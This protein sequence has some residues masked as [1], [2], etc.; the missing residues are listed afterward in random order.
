[1]NRLLRTTVG[2]AVTFVFPIIA[3]AQAN[4]PP[5]NVRVTN[6]PLPVTTSGALPVTADTPLPVSL[7]GPLSLA[8][9]TVADVAT[10]QA[11]V[12]VSGR[13]FQNCVTFDRLSVPP[14]VSSF[15]IAD[16]KAFVVTSV[17]WHARVPSRASKSAVALLFTAVG[18]SVNG[19]SATGVA[20]ADS[21]GAAGGTITFPTG[22][23]VKANQELCIQVQAVPNSNDYAPADGVA[24]GFFADLAP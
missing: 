11:S 4:N 23:I 6:T 8:P 1:M 3:T 7:D 13:S 5:L 10:L 19:P 17:D 20:M 14:T 21:E 24:H 22:V 15:T 9:R 12:A 18:G 16:G 2:I